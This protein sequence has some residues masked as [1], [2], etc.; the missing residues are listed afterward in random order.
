MIIQYSRVHTVDIDV[1]RSGFN[2]QTAEIHVDYIR[3]L[4]LSIVH[5]FPNSSLES[6]DIN[7]RCVRENLVICT[8]P[9]WILPNCGLMFLMFVLP[10]MPI[11]KFDNRTGY[12]RWFCLT[13]H[14]KMIPDLFIEFEIPIIISSFPI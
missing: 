7:A 12:Q 5:Q 11:V 2:Q 3:S 9:F 13:V 6:P 14:F 4:F 10:R 8:L 1:C